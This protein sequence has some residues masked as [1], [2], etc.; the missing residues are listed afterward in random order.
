MEI[1]T[2]TNNNT[3]DRRSLEQIVTRSSEAVMLLDALDPSRPV[4]YVNPAFESMTGYAAGDV[5]GKPWPLLGRAGDRRARAELESAMARAEAVDVE[6]ADARKDGTPWTSRVSFSP[7]HDARGDVR[8]FLVLQREA[9]PASA[10][11]NIEVG[12]LRRELGRARR[13]LDHMNRI[14]QATGLLRY[15]HFTEMLERDLAI[16]RRERR[17]VALMAFEIVELDVYRR[18]FGAKAADS[19][20]RMIGAQISGTLRRAGDLCARHSDSL[21]VASVLGQEVVEAEQLADKIVEN[22]RGLKLH[23]PHA[24]SGRY[25]SVARAV[26]GGVPRADDGVEALVERAR[27]ELLPSI[28]AAKKSYAS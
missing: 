7:L 3:L 18:T 13:K 6:L 14:D 27:R 17:S 28:A 5:L 8:Y 10:A 12:L 1:A 2:E 4:I 23:N 9:P 22:V 11:S 16:A 15:E 24:K 26:V 20:V 19:C 25:V 21:L